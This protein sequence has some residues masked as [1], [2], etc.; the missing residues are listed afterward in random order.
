MTIVL[1]H[2]VLDMGMDDT[3]F[4]LVFVLR[5]V[6]TKDFGEDASKPSTMVLRST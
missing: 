3:L 2:A 1:D 6:F 5:T 4:P